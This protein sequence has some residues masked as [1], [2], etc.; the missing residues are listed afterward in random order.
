MINPKS[1]VIVLTLL[2]ILFGVIVTIYG[3]TL[4]KVLALPCLL[5]SLV[6]I[7]T[8]YGKYVGFVEHIESNKKLD[9]LLERNS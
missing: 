2:F 6:D 9:K 3:S 4:G 1:V 7:C 8:R 5:W